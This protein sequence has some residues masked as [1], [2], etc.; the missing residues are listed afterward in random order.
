M[1]ADLGLRL[2]VVDS[3]EFCGLKLEGDNFTGR[4]LVVTVGD[5]F[6]TRRETGAVD[7]RFNVPLFNCFATAMALSGVHISAGFPT[8]GLN[9]LR[10][11]S[12]CCPCVSNGG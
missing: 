7:G 11:R 8:T 5:E 4:R 9:V 6:G 1:N 3:F 2:V 10:G 12:M